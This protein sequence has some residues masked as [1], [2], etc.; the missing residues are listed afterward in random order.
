MRRGGAAAATWTF[1]GSRRRRGRDVDISVEMAAA[2]WI[3]R[4]DKARAAT[5]TFRR[6]QVRAHRYLASLE[7]GFGN[8]PPLRGEA[9]IELGAGTGVCALA[10]R[11]FGAAKAVATDADVEALRLARHNL[12][13]ND[14]E[15]AHAFRL[16]WRSSSDL[17]R[18]HKTHGR[19]DTALASDV[20][21]QPKDVD[22]FFSCAYFSTDWKSCPL[23]LTLLCASRGRRKQVQRCKNQQERCSRG[24]DPVAVRRHDALTADGRLVLVYEDRIAGFEAVV[25]RAA[26]AAG[27]E[28]VRKPFAGFFDPERDVVDVARGDDGFFSRVVPGNGSW[29]SLR[30]WVGRKA[31]R[32]RAPTTRGR[33]VVV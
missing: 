28:L 29:A 27:F 20:L 13:L 33:A 12:A 30:L 26:A 5:W 1:R 14:F 11:R 17:E 3:F 22:A 16:D 2:T 9:V 32:R 8:E 21:Y 6:E 10:A 7:A 31:P 24:R 23:V 4:G 25:M 15:K 19:F 18:L